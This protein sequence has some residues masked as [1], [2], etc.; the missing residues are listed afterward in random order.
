MVDGYGIELGEELLSIQLILTREAERRSAVPREAGASRVMI[1]PTRTHRGAPRVDR[2]SPR[3]RRAVEGRDRSPNG[4]HPAGTVKLG[5]LE[6]GMVDA[7][8]GTGTARALRRDLML[9][10]TWPA[11]RAHRQVM[12]ALDIEPLEQIRLSFGQDAADLVLKA[13]VEVAP[14]ILEPRDRI[15]RTG[16]DQFVLVQETPGEQGPE[17]ARSSLEASL[18]R[19]LV[20]RGLPE[21]RIGARPVDMDALPA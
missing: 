17:P 13:L 16:R 19:V 20:D 12:A 18:R 8:T 1:D 6:S 10:R 5:M 4:V 15:Y 21:V 7:L 3:P 2:T 9:E 11:A 14:F